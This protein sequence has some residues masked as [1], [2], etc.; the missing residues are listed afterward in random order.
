MRI[1]ELTVEVRD[2]SLERVGQILP[3]DL[4]G[5]K[6]IMR[7]NNVGSWEISLPAAHPM[8]E[9]L[10][11]PGAGIVV[12]GPSGVLISGPTSAAT[13]SKTDSNPQGTWKIQGVDDSVVL[14]ERLAYPDPAVADVTAQGQANDVRTGKAST[15][16][17][18]YVDA[19]IGP[20]AP[21]EREIP[22]LTIAADPLI[23]ST[24]Y[25]SAR[26]DILGELI[27]G[28]ASVDNLGFDIKQTDGQLE[29]S[30]YQPVDRSGYIRMDV[31]NNTLS[32]T[33]YAYGQ[34]ALSRAIVAGQGQGTDRQFLEITSSESLSAET[35]WGRRIET[36]IDQRNTSD[37]NE[38]TQAGNEALADGGQT[39][40]S[41][42]VVP[43]SDLT[44]KYGVDWNL[45]DKVTVDVGGQE[46]QA[47]VATVA[48]S[49]DADG[50]RVGATVGE[51]TGV[52]YEALIAKKQTSTAKRVNAL[53]RK[54]GGG[55]VASIM[56]QE[57]KNDQGAVLSKGQ[58]V[59][60]SGANGTNVL[61]KRAQAN[62]EA[63]SS[64][65]LG[66]LAE[67]L[68]V[69]GIGKIIT[70]GL[71]GGLNTSTA[72]AGDPVWLSPTTA[73][74]LVYGLANKPSAPNHLVY[75]GVVLRSNANNGEIYV[76]IQ[77]G[78]ELD[79]LHD[80][81]ITSPVA[82]QVIV[83]DPT[84]SFWQNGE[85]SSGITFSDTAP[86]NPKD[87]DLWIRTVDGTLF[88]RWND[89]NTSQ[90][91]EVK[92][93]NNYTGDTQFNA[94]SSRMSAVESVTTTQT[95][96]ISTLTS[97]VNNMRAGYYIRQFFVEIDTAN[98]SFGTGWTNLYT[99]G[100]YSGFKAGSKVLF[101]YQ[102]PLRNDSYSWG[103]VY[104]EPQVT[105]NNSTWKSLG[106]S[107]YDGSVM[108]ESAADIATYSKT[109]LI[110]PALEGVTS[111]F[112]FRFRFY[113]KT[114]DGTGLWNQDHAINAVSGTV[115]NATGANL[116][117]H[118]ATFHIEE[119]AT[120]Q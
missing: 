20:L 96:Q 70:E 47:I 60:V 68:A 102:L 95:S 32:K 15:V 98:R 11:Q 13:N 90:W 53:E 49:I 81:K 44:M 66:L 84:N 59:Y 33:E 69:N 63:T 105:F 10:R 26:F 91:V 107:G 5:F 41:I 78:F 42:D 31:L 37:V 112:T 67:D 73:G 86:T 21:V 6:A 114:Y 72:T 65:T 104:I 8:A 109:L 93:P 35:L 12:T 29:F 79:E 88:V 3:A 24:V 1:E 62:A 54:E 14:G 76:K 16:I 108:H 55:A 74:G 71:L 39:L 64:K 40:T 50:V 22:G 77:N 99:G 19:N 75:I 61:V 51:A 48:L 82:N 9:A 106:S 34:H 120:G 80:V 119:L 17:M 110:D 111:D 56:T 94:F 57:V 116:N 100:L 83:R 7:F 25:G 46:V 28:L 103:G 18:N 113:V 45:G 115:A 4:V 85:G 27:S 97:Q 43:S 2:G 23:G 89:G 101:T 118:F 30:V 87:K 36:F 58:A 38:L 92:N 117:Q 52:D